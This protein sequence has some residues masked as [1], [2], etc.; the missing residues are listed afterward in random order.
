[1]ILLLI[2]VIY[3]TSTSSGAFWVTKKS[4]N[5]SGSMYVANSCIHSGNNN[6]ES[7]HSGTTIYQ[8]TV[9]TN[10]FQEADAHCKY[11]TGVPSGDGDGYHTTT[12]GSYRAKSTFTLTGIIDQSSGGSSHSYLD[13]IVTLYYYSG[14][15]INV[16]TTSYRISGGNFDGSSYTVTTSSGYVSSGENLHIKIEIHLHADGTY[17]EGNIQN[18]FYGGSNDIVINSY[19]FQYYDTGPII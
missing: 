1:M 15:V 18:Y 9:V 7:S 13:L 8:S 19:Q 16:G 17:S 6:P 14:S 5:W 12:S 11:D 2:A 4:A 10:L 3:S